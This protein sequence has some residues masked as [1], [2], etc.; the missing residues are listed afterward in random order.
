MGCFL[1]SFKLTLV[2]LLCVNASCASSLRPCENVFPTLDNL[3]Y[4]SSGQTL[5]GLLQALSH[6]LC[7]CG[8]RSCICV[9]RSSPLTTVAYFNGVKYCVLWFAEVQLP[10][11]HFLMARDRY[12]PFFHCSVFCFRTGF[13][14]L[15]L[16]RRI[17]LLVEKLCALEEWAQ[18]TGMG[19]GTGRR[20]II[21][22]C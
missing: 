20:N 16:L 5:V 14:S 2:C 8:T 1:F 12:A 17:F 6:N 4:I 13:A 11:I 7:F 22:N 3:L 18:V 19:L 9:V 21:R 10:T 15:Q